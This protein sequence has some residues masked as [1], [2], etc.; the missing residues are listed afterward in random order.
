MS[1]LVQGSRA[2]VAASEHVRG[3]QVSTCMSLRR[4]QESNHYCHESYYSS[5]IGRINSLPVLYEEK[6][7]QVRCY[8]SDGFGNGHVLYDKGRLP[9]SV[10][11]SGG[12]RSKEQQRAEQSNIDFL[13]KFDDVAKV[14]FERLM[15]DSKFSDNFLQYLH[16]N[17][18]TKIHLDKAH[19]LVRM[20]ILPENQTLKGV[21][22][23]SKTVLQ[24]LK[25]MKLIHSE[26]HLK[27]KYSEPE[28][29]R[30]CLRLRLLLRGIPRVQMSNDP[31]HYHFLLRFYFSKRVKQVVLIELTDK[32][33]RDVKV[34]TGM[35]TKVAA[36]FIPGIGIAFP[37]S[38]CRYMDLD[39]T[40]VAL[41]NS[42]LVML[43]DDDSD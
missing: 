20:K 7:V 27:V 10:G 43:T 31:S 30:L 8:R 9:P 14:Q 12:R 33:A 1:R 28:P 25:T 5:G 38:E 6:W 26:N 36:A 39:G 41:D 22:Q 40:T 19:P 13:Y 18:E 24:S 42:D 4:Y 34:G 35:L 11:A 21:E 29:N 17:V 16:E 37:G 23:F 2:L 32:T 15:Q 3:S